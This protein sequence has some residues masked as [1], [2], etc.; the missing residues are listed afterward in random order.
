MRRSQPLF[1]LAVEFAQLNWDANLMQGS[2]LNSTLG[3]TQ[4]SR[5]CWPMW[6]PMC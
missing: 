4:S 3:S 6:P 5:R 1:E 2:R